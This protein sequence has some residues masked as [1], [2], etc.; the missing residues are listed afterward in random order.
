MAIYECAK[1]E[2]EECA[3]HPFRYHLGPACRC[4]V[5]GTYRVVRLRKRD[6]IDR[7]RGGFLNLLERLVGGGK[8][9]HCRWCRMQFYDRRKTVGELPASELPETLP[10]VSKTPDIEPA[11]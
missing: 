11:K 6:H 8:L 5:C 10:E 2:S 7:L 3:P 1:C 4:P 9:Y